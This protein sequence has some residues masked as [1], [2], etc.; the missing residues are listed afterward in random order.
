MTTPDIDPKEAYR[1]NIAAYFYA[2]VCLEAEQIIVET[3]RVEG[4]HYAAMRR[5]LEQMNVLVYADALIEKLRRMGY[6]LEKQSHENQ[7]NPARGA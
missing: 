5:V 6:G 3:G 1:A 7:T 4:A 2:L